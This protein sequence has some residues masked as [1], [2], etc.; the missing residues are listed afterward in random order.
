MRYD[1]YLTLARRQYGAR[2]SSHQLDARFVPYF[3][4]GERIKVECTYGD[5]TETATGT[6][7]VTSGWVPVFLL[8]RSSRAHGSSYVL[9]PE[10][11]IIGRKVGRTYHP[12]VA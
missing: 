12:V 8:M 1:D 5:D 10:H 6:I 9:G 4:S 7:G 2:F 3:N 11:R